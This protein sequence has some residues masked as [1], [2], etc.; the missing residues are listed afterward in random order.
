MPECTLTFLVPGGGVECEGPQQSQA[1]CT[2]GT[3]IGRIT[4]ISYEAHDAEH[5]APFEINAGLNDAWVSDGAPF[6]GLFVTVFPELGLVFVAWFTFDTALP[7]ENAAVFGSGGQRWVTAVGPYEGNAASLKAELTTG[8]AFDSAEPMPQQD[9]DY[10]TVELQ[11]ENCGQGK[12]SYEF[13]PVGL[14]GS[15]VIRRAIDDNSLCEALSSG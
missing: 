3:Y 15:F 11:F 14:S 8:G 4:S 10:G 7:E 2:H 5:G 1:I 9:T 13:P 6:Q 12:V